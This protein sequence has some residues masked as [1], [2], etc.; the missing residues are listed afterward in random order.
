MTAAAK[1][2]AL[3]AVFVAFPVVVGRALRVLGE[4]DPVDDEHEW[5]AKS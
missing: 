1:V 5:W 3:V 2:L 4:D